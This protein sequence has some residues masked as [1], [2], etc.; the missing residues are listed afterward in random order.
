[1][2]LGT[3]YLDLQTQ[4]DTHIGR[5]L[6]ELNRSFVTATLAHLQTSGFASVTPHH[7]HIIAQIDVRGSAIADVLKR[8]GVTKQS[9]SNTLGILESNGFVQRVVS[10]EDGR[11]RCVKFTEKG[12][13]LLRAGIDA[14]KEVETQ[15]AALLGESNFQDLKRTLG[16]L[17]RKTHDE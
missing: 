15:Y 4:R 13:Q 5:Y 9:L 10:E 17:H 8:S 3:K 16:E 6:I 2:T 11:S 14:V 12:L 7:I 1:M